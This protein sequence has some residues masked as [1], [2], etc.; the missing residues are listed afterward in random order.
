MLKDDKGLTI[1]EYILGGALVLAIVG[2]S[3]WGIATS[4]SAQGGNVDAAVDG[5][6]AQP[7]W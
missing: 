7:S 6:P 4:V 2:L 3:V 1:V 5:M